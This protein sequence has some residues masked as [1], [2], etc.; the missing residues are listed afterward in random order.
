[1]NTLEVSVYADF[2]LE[3][4]YWVVALIVIAFV[5]LFALIDRAHEKK[6]ELGSYSNEAEDKYIQALGGR[7]NV[8]YHELIG[9]RIVV[10]LVDY[11]KLNQEML[12]E[13]GVTGF[14][15]KS[16]QI[17]LV[18]KDN[19]ALTYQHLFPEDEKR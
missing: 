4:L 3:N 17:T 9:S 10:K 6:A 15:E 18:I 16:D 5:V 14:I 2:F 7:D 1:M 19:A 11:S 12:K 13:A 8:S